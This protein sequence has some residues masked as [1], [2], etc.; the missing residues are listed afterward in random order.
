MV[1][2]LSKEEI[3]IHTVSNTTLNDG[4]AN[5]SSLSTELLISFLS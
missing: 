4:V 3:Q 2:K 1:V 5:I